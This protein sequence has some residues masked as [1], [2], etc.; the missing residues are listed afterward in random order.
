MR[1]VIYSLF[2][3]FILALVP[4]VSGGVFENV[5][6]IGEITYLEPS[7]NLSFDDYFVKLYSV[8]EDSVSLMIYRDGY[9]I[10]LFD[11]YPGETRVYDG[12]SLR[13]V[14]LTDGVPLVGVCG[15]E[16][17]LVWCE[18]DYVV[19]EWARPVKVGDWDL[20]ATAFGEDFVNISTIRVFPG[21]GSGRLPASKK[22]DEGESYQDLFYEG[23]EKSYGDRFK[24]CITDIDS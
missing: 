19:L 3:L 15:L 23:G 21:P 11:L 6:C 10:R 1:W 13:F 8:D 22:L 7:G 4:S 18:I 24:I 16:N 14:E 2:V 12:Y 17:G 20:K 9:F 5:E